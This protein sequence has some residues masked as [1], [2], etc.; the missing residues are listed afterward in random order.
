QRPQY[1]RQASSVA[2]RVGMTWTGIIQRSVRRVWIT[3]NINILCRTLAWSLVP[4]GQRRARVDCERRCF[5]C[6]AE[7]KVRRWWVLL[8]IEDVDLDAIAENHVP[9]LLICAA[10]AEPFGLNPHGHCDTWLGLASRRH[11][12]R[13]AAVEAAG[14]D[15]MGRRGLT[16]ERAGRVDRHRVCG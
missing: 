3:A 9:R 14:R 12:H 1:Q 11:C 7:R 10:R 5:T 13:V 16:S 6:S 8:R 15:R 4:D 2:R